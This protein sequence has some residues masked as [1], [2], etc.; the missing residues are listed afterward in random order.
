MMRFWTYGQNNSGGSFDF[1][2][3][4]GISH[5]VIVEA[6]TSGEADAKADSIGLYWNGCE[7]GR[8]CECCGDRWSSSWGDGDA[9]P[10]VYG[11]PVEQVEHSWMAPDPEAYVHY[12]DGRVVGFPTPLP[13]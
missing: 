1:D 9:S 13:A 6:A 5:F 8:D 11:K 4:A 3:D 12:A 2:A 7:D 10:T